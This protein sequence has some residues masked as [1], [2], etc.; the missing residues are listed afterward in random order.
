MFCGL[1]SQ[2]NSNIGP[3]NTSKEAME[4][5]WERMASI[6]VSAGLEVLTRKA[7][8][9]RRQEHKQKMKDWNDIPES[10]FWKRVMQ[11][12]G[13]VLIALLITAHIYY[14]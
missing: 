7:G 4:A 5:T 14:A 11:A 13:I 10:L 2:P 8:S 9:R 3:E 12:S 1:D 6:S